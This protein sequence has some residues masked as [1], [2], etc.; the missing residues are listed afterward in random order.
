MDTFALTK[1][2]QATRMLS[3]AKSLDEITHIIDIAE[4]ARTYARAAKLGLEAQNY[5]AEICL[6]AKRKAGE[7]LRQLERTPE[8]RPP[9]LGTRAEFISEYSSTIQEAEITPREAGRW[10]QIARV[11]DEVFRDFVEQTK[12]SGGELTQAGA[13]RVAREQ[14]KELIPPPMP[15]GKFRIVYA[16]PPW[17][18]GN[19]MPDYMGVQ[20][21]HYPLMTVKE[22]CLM[23]ISEIVEDNAILFLWVTSPILEEAFEMVKAWGFKYKASFV[24]DKVKHVMG[25]YNSVRHEFLLVCTR[26][27]CQPDNIKLFDSVV[28]EERTT[29][30]SKPEIFREYIDTL[31]TQGR[32]IEL[33][34]RSQHENWEAF[35]NE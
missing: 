22:L 16:D 34:A 10:Q 30:S 32:R 21:D 17:K 12:A 26:G 20:D 25:H 23:P 11:S 5:A 7:F 24:W 4:A 31:Y 6:L 13:L 28:T 33:F 18:Y 2:D 15:S 9:K 29:H 35:S 27:S 14:N 1:L 3:E 8:G 19:T